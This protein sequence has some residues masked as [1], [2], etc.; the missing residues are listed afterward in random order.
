M[1]GVCEEGVWDEGH[2][3]GEGSGRRG[4]EWA[5]QL[6]QKP[7]LGSLTGRRQVEHEYA[8]ADETRVWGR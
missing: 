1:G 7:L 3:I 6:R 5:A 4:V 8:H 2:V